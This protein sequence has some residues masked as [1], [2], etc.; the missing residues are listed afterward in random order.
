MMPLQESING[1]IP[2]CFEVNLRTKKEIYGI[3]HM[4]FC[5]TELQPKILKANRYE[6]HQGR[7]IMKEMG[8][9]GLLG[10][11]IPSRYGGSGLG[12]VSYGLLATEVERVDSAYRSCMSVQ[13]SLVMYPIFK[14]ARE[15]N[16]LKYLPELA[17]GNIIGCFGLTEPNHG[18][19]PS[20]METTATF[21]AGTNEFILNGTKN[22]ITNSPIADL[23]VI[24][25]R[26][27]ETK[28][29]R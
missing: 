20:S 18:S 25:A 21:D 23:F 5:Q 27:T 26:N 15:E 17:S 7:H 9:I 13:S 2:F 28:Q 1:R 8:S 11:T 24:W 3:R 4:T 10:S 14:Y 16:K 22:W 19:D 12:Y 29:I 6:D